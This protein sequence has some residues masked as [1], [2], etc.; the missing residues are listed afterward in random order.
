M[1]QIGPYNIKN[2]VI[3]AP[4]AGITDAPFR[5][6]CRQFGL[7]LA[8]SEMTLANP[9]V[10]HTRKSQLRCDFSDDPSPVAVQIAGSE[11]EQMADAARFQVDAGAEIIDINMGCPAKKVCQKAAGSALLS[12]EKKV[13]QILSS[14]V[15]AIEVPVS[16]KI[17]TGPDSS[18]RNV[19]NI[20]RI[21]EQN[22]IALLSIHG[23]T[24]A[25]RFLGE[26]EYDSIQ[27]AKAQVSMPVVANG[28]INTSQK[29]KLVMKQTLADGIMIGRAALGQP[30]LIQELTNALKNQS[31][32]TCPINFEQKKAVIQQHIAAI[33]A[34]YGPSQGV[35]L[36]RKHMGWYLQH[37][38]MPEKRKDFM[39][40]Q[41]AEA[42]LDFIHVL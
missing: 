33:H 28:D 2:P 5:K 27:S 1:F 7:Q 10:W 37:L 34:F 23:R 21:A 12:D 3:L 18:N 22:G 31:E 32:S 6:V 35:R 39:L 25:D 16:L 17:R 11:P 9:A 30:W 14:V 20:A 13:D 26:A 15:K 24:R 19:V 42:Q 36:S 40:L 8:F 41:Q 29:A 4:M 38:S